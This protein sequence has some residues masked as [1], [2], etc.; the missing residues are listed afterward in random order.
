M[1]DE[2]EETAPGIWLTPYGLS[3]GAGTDLQ[4]V[5]NVVSDVGQTVHTSREEAVVHRRENTASP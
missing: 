2:I 4:R 1:T 3:L 5:A